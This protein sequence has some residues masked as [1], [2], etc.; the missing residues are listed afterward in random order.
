[1]PRFHSDS[2]GPNTNE[3]SKWRDLG[4][5]FA[6]MNFKEPVYSTNVL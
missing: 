6:I 1:M 5:A 4:K 2:K 3:N